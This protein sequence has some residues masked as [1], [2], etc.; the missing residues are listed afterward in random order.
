M[1]ELRWAPLFVMDL[2]V[3]R[4]AAQPIGSIPVGWRGV[5]PVDGGT[6]EGDRL[7]GTVNSGGADWITMRSDTVML[8][9]VRLTLLTHDGATIGMTYA[10][11]ATPHDPANFARFAQ[12]EIL[13]D[14]DMYI[15]TTPRFETGDDRYAWLN[16]VIAV[17]NGRRTEAGG[18]Y[19]VF[20]IK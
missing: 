14:E 9:D 1:D 4:A 17:T 7:R 3:G 10:G 13:P 8:I 18:S 20:E 5:F 11:L 19:H 16:R 2:T 12:R 15:H 6:F